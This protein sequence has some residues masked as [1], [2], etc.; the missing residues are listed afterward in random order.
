LLADLQVAR[1]NGTFT[2]RFARLC[3]VGLLVIDDFGLRPLSAQG[4]ED[5]Y[6]LIRE[7]YEHKPLIITSNRAFSEWPDA[8]ATGS[9]RALCSIGSP[10][11]P[12]PWSSPA[13]AT[14][15]RGR[16]NGKEVI[17]ETDSK[18]PKNSF[19]RTA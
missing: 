9:S 2:R 7:R 11:I 17:P 5:L 19:S 14:V 1:A 16:T 12:I 13:R 10:I 6:E 15:Q 4:A 8:F 18:V 3:S